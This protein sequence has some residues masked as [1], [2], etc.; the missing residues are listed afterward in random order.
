[1]YEVNILALIAKSVMSL[2]GLSFASARPAPQ[3]CVSVLVVWR[4]QEVQIELIDTSNPNT[5]QLQFFPV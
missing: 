3:P 2:N 4:I 1:M 5:Y